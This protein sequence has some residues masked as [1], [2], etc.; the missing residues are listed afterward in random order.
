MI[1]ISQNDENKLSNKINKNEQRQTII[2][3]F[4]SGI[5][6]EI[7]A[8]QLDIELDEV[9]KVIQN[10]SD[11]TD[12]EKKYLQNNPNNRPMSVFY[13]DA[14]VDIPKIISSA[15]SSM[16]KALRT[17]PVFT[18]PFNET[19]EILSHYSVTKI[20]SIILHI[21][22]VGSTK[23]SMT[24]PIERISK[25]IQA[26]TQEMTKIIRLYGGYVL[27]YIGDAIIGFFMVDTDNLYLPCINAI[28]CAKTM[29][30]VINQGFN[31]V[32][33][34]YD[35]PEMGVRIGIDYG[36][37]VVVKYLTDSENTTSFD[38][39]HTKQKPPKNKTDTKQPIYDI[40][41]YT[42][43]IAT[44]M[45]AYAKV[46]H[47]IVGQLIYDILSKE[48]QSYFTL[49]DTRPENWNYISDETGTIYKLYI[50]RT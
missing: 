49:I 20:N 35:Y 34:Q 30:K 37:N 19:Q 43:S 38:G 28:N 7:I 24:L 18:F 31:P 44:K 32:L 2:N 36:E 47:I 48:E 6:L 22:I 23:L 11:R 40:L 41:G 27:K 29:I 13:L 3:L 16:W 17:D 12:I 14:V 50:N 42:I 5:P 39:G 46:D 8:L 21:D 10:I 33:S 1:K 4:D 15:Q 26:F 45:T 25:I 9:N